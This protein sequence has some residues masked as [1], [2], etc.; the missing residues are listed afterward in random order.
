MKIAESYQADIYFYSQIYNVQIHKRQEKKKTYIGHLIHMTMGIFPVVW[1][2]QVLIN[3]NDRDEGA[4]S[5][6]SISR[7]I[8]PHLSHP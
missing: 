3:M 8:D 5:P 6:Q 4:T 2:R 1:G 7:G